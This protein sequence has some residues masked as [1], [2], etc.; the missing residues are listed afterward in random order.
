ML[1]KNR[2]LLQSIPRVVMC[3]RKFGDLSKHCAGHGRRGRLG[4]PGLLGPVIQPQATRTILPL[5]VSV[6]MVT[7]SWQNSIVTG[8][9]G[10]I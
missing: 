5:L 2:Q 4:E 6:S 9:P 10:L 7:R 1:V 3:R 8:S